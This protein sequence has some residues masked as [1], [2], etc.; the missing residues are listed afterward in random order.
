MSVFSLI[1]QMLRGVAFLAQIT[2]FIMLHIIEY[3]IRPLYYPL[4]G[5]MLKN[6]LKREPN[7]FI[8]QSFAYTFMA[9]YNIKVVALNDVISFFFKCF[10][11]KNEGTIKKQRGATIHCHVI[12][13]I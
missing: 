3:A 7:E 8:T 5:T 9:V 1:E 4:F 10:I 13:I 6:I 11:H 2:T 12:I